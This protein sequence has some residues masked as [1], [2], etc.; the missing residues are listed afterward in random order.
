M[1]PD[2]NQQKAKSNRS[3]KTLHGAKDFVHASEISTNLFWA[4]YYRPDPGSEA[5]SVWDTRFTKLCNQLAKFVKEVK[6][7]VFPG[8]VV[9]CLHTH[10]YRARHKGD[11][12]DAESICD[13]T[14]PDHPVRKSLMIKPSNDGPV[15]IMELDK[16][17]SMW[18][19]SGLRNH[20]DAP[21]SS[22]IPRTAPAAQ[23]AVGP[24]PAAQPVSGL[25]PGAAPKPDAASRPPTGSTGGARRRARPAD[26]PEEGEE[27]INSPEQ[28]EPPTKRRKTTA[29]RRQ[30]PRTKVVQADPPPATVAV[31]PLSSSRRPRKTGHEAPPAPATPLAP[32]APPAPA[33]PPTPAAVPPAG[34]A[35]SALDTA[36][37]EFPEKVILAHLTM[38]PDVV[39]L[40][41]RQRKQQC[42]VETFKNTT[43]HACQKGHTKCSHLDVIST[44]PRLTFLV[45]NIT[46]QCED[47]ARFP[48]A[49]L[50]PRGVD[51]EAVPVPGWVLRQAEEREVGQRGRGHRGGNCGRQSRS[52]SRGDAT[53]AVD[54]EGDPADRG[55]KKPRGHPAHRA[56]KRQP[57]ASS[58]RGMAP[59]PPKQA[60]GASETAG[61]ALRSRSA[62]AKKA[63]PEPSSAAQTELSRTGS[64]SSAPPPPT[65]DASTPGPCPT[66]ADD[67][68]AG[69]CDDGRPADFDEGMVVDEPAPLRSSTSRA[70]TTLRSTEVLRAPPVTSQSWRNVLQLAPP[71]GPSR[72]PGAMREQLPPILLKGPSVPPLRQAPPVSAPIREKSQHICR[73]LDM[74][75]F[76]ATARVD[77][78]TDPAAII[79]NCASE[80]TQL[81]HEVREASE[82]NLKITDVLDVMVSAIENLP[83]VPLNERA[84]QDMLE[85]SCTLIGVYS[86]TWD[87]MK[88]MTDK[89]RSLRES[90]DVPGG[91]EGPAEPVDV[92]RVAKQVM[93]PLFDRL[94]GR[95]IRNMEDLVEGLSRQ[96]KKMADVYSG[97]WADYTERAQKMQELLLPV[98]ENMAAV[99]RDLR[100]V[101]SSIFN[102]NVNNKLNDLQVK[103]D[104]LTNWVGSALQ[105]G[106]EPGEYTLMWVVCKMINRLNALSQEVEHLLQQRTPAPAPPASV[107]DFDRR[108][109]MYLGQFGLTPNVLRQLGSLHQPSGPTGAPST[110][111]GNR[112]E[113]DPSAGSAGPSSMTDP[114]AP[115]AFPTTP[116]RSQLPSSQGGTS[117]RAPGSRRS[118]GSGSASTRILDRPE[119]AGSG[120]HTGSGTRK[121]AASG[122]GTTRISDWPKGSPPGTPTHKSKGKHTPRTMALATAASAT[123]FGPQLPAGPSNPSPAG[124]PM[125][126]KQQWRFARSTA[127]DPSKQRDCELRADRLQSRQPTVRGT[128]EEPL[129]SSYLL[130]GD[131]DMTESSTGQEVTEDSQAEELDAEVAEVAQ[132]DVTME[133]NSED[134]F[135]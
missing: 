133:D 68:G 105:D 42:T 10:N 22:L 74:S 65:S 33:A 116:I 37:P 97:E 122:S 131:L 108:V 67:S 35:A 93:E 75:T 78:G 38:H 59:H 15:T 98:K 115:P 120:S 99:A 57:S 20:P 79:R 48:H 19:D 47:V 39:H 36:F 66:D 127:G 87:H 114:L 124:T 55:S 109:R 102:G 30:T 104:D 86:T 52:M 80:I 31:I 46:K 14:A 32:T 129:G 49:A 44:E 111:R 60:A 1:Q 118:T 58:D 126:G 135:T 63:G 25:E 76:F 112:H 95:I 27:E 41:C 70:R 106:E 16:I 130:P 7:E 110:P 9:R 73:R 117:G 72:F 82:M 132:R 77:Y 96:L 50:T 12:V 5:R 101:S 121:S 134:T 100:D 62:T 83:T 28:P 11:T 53:E 119:R 23:P 6:I 107:D 18:W 61:R 88:R 71:A 56:T 64:V 29:P 89:V 13:A 34:P 85:Y 123:F 90:V 8:F 69:A 94:C 84:L 43:C 81:G 21:I 4:W 54:D 92:R 45:W 113:D 125:G 128:R 40:S 2:H 17:M 24:S 3:K 91:R 51:V 26:D 103:V